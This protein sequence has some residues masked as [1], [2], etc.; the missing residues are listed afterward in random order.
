M[1]GPVRC[2]PEPPI[3]KVYPSGSARATWADPIAPLLPGRFSTKNCCL[4]AAESSVAS[5]RPNWSALPP[6]AKATTI[7]TGRLG[8]SS[9]RGCGPGHRQTVA[10]S[11]A[12]KPPDRPIPCPFLRSG[13]LGEGGVAHRPFMPLAA[14]WTKGAEIP[15]ADA[16]KGADL[17]LDAA[18]NLSSRLRAN[19][20]EMFH[21]GLH[22]ED[23]MRFRRSLPSHLKTRQCDNAPVSCRPRAPDAIK[24]YPDAART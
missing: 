19:K 15:F 1:A 8:H 21:H 12:A 2:G 18:V 11:T 22:G 3:N 24:S 17:G 13:G 20:E 9:A 16:Q 10:T 7:L 5:R 23:F 14:R 4:S 6:G